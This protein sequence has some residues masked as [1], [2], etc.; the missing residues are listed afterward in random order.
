[1]GGGGVKLPLQLKC[2]IKCDTSV[3]NFR[4]DYTYHPNVFSSTRQPT[5]TKLAFSLP[6]DGGVH[7]VISKP[8]GKWSAE[9]NCWTW[10]IGT[11]PP[12]ENPGEGDSENRCTIVCG[13][14]LSFLIKY[15]SHLPL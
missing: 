10:V 5:L 13:F 15:D 14:F 11:V 3:T 2:Y 12:V 1:M 6:M 7:N 4:A 8:T 9:N